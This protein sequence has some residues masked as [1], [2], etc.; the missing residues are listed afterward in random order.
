M[1][2][3]LIFLIDYK[4][5]EPKIIKDPHLS[6]LYRKW[7]APRT[8][9]TILLIHGLGGHSGRWQGLAEFLLKNNISSYALELK[10]FGETSN[11]KG[12]INSFNTYFNDILTLYQCIRKEYPNKKIFISGESLGC[13]LSFLLVIKEPKI[14]R[15]LIC[16]SPVFKST[17]AFSFM[18]H[19]TIIFASI[20][21]P[22]K[23]IK[24]PFDSAMCTQDTTYQKFLDQ[25]KREHR[26]ASARLLTLTFFS[27]I[28]ALFIAKQ[29]KTSTLYLVPGKDSFADLKTNLWVF[30]N[31]KIDDKKI[32]QYPSMY[33]ALSIELNKEKVFKNI[34]SWIEAHLN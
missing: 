28:Y 13:L 8:K 6:I 31:L 7:L 14:F 29:L 4:N 23:Q 9:A 26:L 34:L 12:H 16:I 33:H 2:F 24:V 10:G 17:L 25:D 1:E 22:K 18:D 19:I 30:K 21:N 11:L 32:I 5:M 3:S 20:F 15:G 27:Q